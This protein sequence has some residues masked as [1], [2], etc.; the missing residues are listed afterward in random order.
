MKNNKLRC[1]SMIILVCIIASCAV[2]S[3]CAA[4]YRKGNNSISDAYSKSIFYERFKAIPLTGDGPTDAVAIALSQI[5]YQ[6]GNSNGQFGGDI[7][8]NKNYTEYNYNFGSFDGY[9]D[10]GDNEDAGVS[11]H[12]CASFVSFCLYQSGCHDLSKLTDWCRNHYGDSKYVWKEL[13]CQNW[14]NQLKN[15]DMFKPSTA[16]GGSYAPTTGDLI[17]FTY[18]SKSSSHV[19]IVVYSDTHY[20]YT[21]EGNTSSGTGLESNGGGVYFKRYEFSNSAI[22]GYGKL[23]YKRDPNVELID[24]SGKNA[25]AGLYISIDEKSVFK[26]ADDTEATY[27]LPRYSVFRVDEVCGGGLLFGS[28]NIDGTEVEGYVINNNNRVV[29]ITASKQVESPDVPT[30]PTDGSTEETTD[31]TTEVTTE[32]TTEEVTDATGGGTTEEP[33]DE[34]KTDNTEDITTEQPAE[35]TTDNTGESTEE[36]T[37]TGENPEQ[38]GDAQTNNDSNGTTE[39]KTT[40]D[41]AN[42]TT[43]RKGCRSGIVSISAFFICMTSAVYYLIRKKKYD[44]A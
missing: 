16:F 6:E 18:D 8:G 29:Q 10:Y 27:I 2:L 9:G 34:K 19:G 41:K 28:F 4:E 11:Y 23:P 5:G 40:D 42:S 24:Y 3:V 33:T 1:I 25:T 15:F 7:A 21:V 13:S 22:M 32:Q 30:P 26:N 14:V 38:T 35:I 17:F 37:A 44:R 43:E 20:V 39:D 36:N 12:W 31:Q